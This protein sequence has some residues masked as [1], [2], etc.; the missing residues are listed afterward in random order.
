MD[1]TAYLIVTP[2]VTG[3]VIFL[4]VMTIGYKK[5]TLGVALFWYLL[6]CIL[7]LTGSYLELFAKTEKW[8]LYF[9]ALQHLALP[10]I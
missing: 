7:F 8:V 9:A 2:V 10:I 1:Y 5:I 6:G 3:V 4:M